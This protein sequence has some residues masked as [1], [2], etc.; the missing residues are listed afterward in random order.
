MCVCVCVCVN[1]CGVFL[2]PPPLVW[3]VLGERARGGVCFSVSLSRLTF[4][5]TSALWRAA[6]VLRVCR[7]VHHGWG[8]LSLSRSLS[9]SLYVSL[10]VSPLV[11]LTHL[12]PPLTYYYCSVIYLHKHQNIVVDFF[13][14]F[15]GVEVI[16]LYPGRPNCS[17]LMAILIFLFFC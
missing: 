17:Q 11:L 14:F 1:I 4:A 6:A 2:F 7:Q 15:Y 5:R 3:F 12:A 10:S 8:G 13:F 16:F 9:L